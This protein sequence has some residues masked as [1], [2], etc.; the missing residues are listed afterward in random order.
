M[1]NCELEGVSVV[2]LGNFNPSIFQP[3]WLGQQ[4]IIR[5][6][7]GEEANVQI[8][9]PQVTSFSVDWLTLQVTQD[10][11]T[12]ATVDSAHFE[13]LRD[14]VVAIFTI[15]EHTPLKQMGINRDMHYRM[16]NEASWHA[17]GNTLAPKEKWESLLQ[18]PGLATLSVRGVRSNST[19]RFVMVTVQPS[20][21]IQPGVY[22]A[23]NE[24]FETDADG[25]GSTEQL[26]NTLKT[27]WDSAQKY[28][29]D[30]AETLLDGVIK[31]D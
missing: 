15:L 21:R 1:L 24:H 19:S 5:P 11:F 20:Q 31:E 30:L 25:K 27:S 18:N 17:V 9:A 4:G 13:V 28:S 26:I 7:E 22:I 2:L 10:R 8:I 14:L 23:T 12:A 16:P 29:K 3:A 6:I